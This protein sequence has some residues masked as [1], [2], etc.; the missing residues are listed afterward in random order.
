MNLGLCTNDLKPKGSRMV[1]SVL[2][3]EPGGDPREQ[4]FEGQW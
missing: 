3:P 2:Q 4:C 1:G